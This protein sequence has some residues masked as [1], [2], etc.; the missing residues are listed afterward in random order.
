[1]QIV[2]VRFIKDTQCAQTGWEFYPAG[3]S[4]HF[5]ANQAGWL[6][7]HGRAVSG[8]S[9]TPAN[10]DL[11]PLAQLEPEDPPPDYSGMTVKQLK[12]AMVDAGI[13]VKSGMRKADL[14]AALE[15]NNDD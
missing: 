12:A 13:T 7:E 10:P 4:A 9:P 14:I 1:M 6:F 2:K 11:A 8:E 5:Y 3:A 15:D